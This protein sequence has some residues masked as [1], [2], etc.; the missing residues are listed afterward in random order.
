MVGGKIMIL[1]LMAFIILVGTMGSLELD[2][3]DFSQT[4][5]QLLLAGALFVISEQ[6]NR[7]KTLK[8]SLEWEK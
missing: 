7:I 2:R 8:K 3:I 6:K 5:I 4:V 1:K